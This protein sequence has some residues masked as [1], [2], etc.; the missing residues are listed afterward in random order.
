MKTLAGFLRAEGGRRDGRKDSHAGYAQFQKKKN[1]ELILSNHP[2]MCQSCN[3]GSTGCQLKTLANTMDT[4]F[5]NYA[6]NQEVITANQI[7]E[8]DDGISIMRDPNRC[9]PLQKM[10]QHL[11]QPARLSAPST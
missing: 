10:H 5:A 7:M 4:E 2:A 8:I 1:L 3:R 11:P 6:K 9:I